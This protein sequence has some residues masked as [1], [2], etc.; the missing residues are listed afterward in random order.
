MTWP[1][2]PGGV[3]DG[4]VVGGGEVEPHRCVDVL[5]GLVPGVPRLNR[6]PVN[7]GRLHGWRCAG[8]GNLEEAENE[9]ADQE[10]KEGVVDFVGEFFVFSLF[11]FFFQFL[12]RSAAGNVT[13]RVNFPTVGGIVDRRVDPK[14][15]IIIYQKS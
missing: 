1:A 12:S 13:L 2:E 7:D 4:N 10:R 15:S 6:L 11:S 8:D 5:V 9:V 14:I 3:V